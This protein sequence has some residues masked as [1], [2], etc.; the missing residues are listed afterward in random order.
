M[1]EEDSREELLS[2]PVVY[3]Q[4]RGKGFLGLSPWLHVLEVGT[5]ILVSWERKKQLFPTPGYETEK[6]TL[7]FTSTISAWN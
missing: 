3:N 6:Q 2:L 7:H 1:P 5:H 4:G